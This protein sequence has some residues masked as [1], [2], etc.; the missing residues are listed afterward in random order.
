MN[1]RGRFFLAAD[2]GG[3]LGD[4]LEYHLIVNLHHSGD[5]VVLGRATRRPRIGDPDNA[6][7]L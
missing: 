5:P 4:L 3:C 2:A 1:N 6:Y 7:E